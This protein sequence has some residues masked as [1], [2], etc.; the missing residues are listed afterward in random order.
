MTAV[1]TPVVQTRSPSSIAAAT[2]Y[3]T[4]GSIAAFEY[5]SW[6]AIG[7]WPTSVSSV[8]ATIE[9]AVGLPAPSTRTTSARAEAESGALSLYVSVPVSVPAAGVGVGLGGADGLGDGATLG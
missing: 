7:F 4:F 5:G 6:N 9:P 1:P 3:V 8:W 2:V